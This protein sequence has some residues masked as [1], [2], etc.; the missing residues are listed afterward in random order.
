MLQAMRS[1]ALRAAAPLLVL[2][3]SAAGSQAASPATPPVPTAPK[4]LRSATPAQ[5]ARLSN[6]QNVAAIQTKKPARDGSF[7]FIVA[8]DNRDGD[9][10]FVR[11]LAK[12]NSYVHGTA[13]P[14][15]ADRSQRPLFM[16]H[17]GDIVPSGKAAEWSNFAAM[18]AAFDAPMV[19]VPGNHEMHTPEGAGNFQQYVGAGDWSFDYAGCRFIG[20]DDSLGS[21]STDSVAYLRSQLGVDGAAHPKRPVPA[22]KFVAFHEPPYYG[23]WVVH[24]TKSD[25]D[26]GRSGEVMA[27]VKAAHA[28]AVF[29]G[30]IHLYDEVDVDR[31]PYIISGGAGAPLYTLG[32]GRTE[33]GFVLV[34]VGPQGVSWDWVSLDEPARH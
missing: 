3:L 8:G 27:A 24:C 30:H 12:M 23:N 13:G 20:L 14:G 29:M 31:T 26:G 34:H 7:S 19:F 1:L 10:T 28:D 18:R 16:L 5:L 15:V 33:Y 11:L 6:A 25:A 32:F 4:V 21:F 17:T 9:A 2:A 22:R